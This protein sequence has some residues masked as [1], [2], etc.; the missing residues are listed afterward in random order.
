MTDLVMQSIDTLSLMDFKPIPTDE[1]KVRCAQMTS[2]VEYFYWWRWSKG[3]EALNN[4]H[5]VSSMTENEILRLISLII[6]KDGFTPGTFD[7]ACQ[8]GGKP[9][10]S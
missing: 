4:E 2:Q 1:L 6:K 3:I 5:I 8:N 9:L 7:H 10:V